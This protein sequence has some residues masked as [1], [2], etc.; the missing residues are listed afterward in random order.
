MN[1]MSFDLNLLLVFDA[2]MTE[3]SVTAA[4]AKVGLSQPAMSNALA[5]LRD[6]LGDRL[7][8]RGQKRMVPTPRAL[9][10]APDIEA[11]LHHLRIAVQGREFTPTSSTVRFRLAT[12]DEIELFLLPTVIKKL[13]V[14]APGISVSCARLQGLFR[15]PETDL[16][17]G[18]LDFAFGSFPNPAPVESSLFAHTLYE[19]KFVCIVRAGHPVTKKGLSFAEFCKLKHVVTFYP[20]AGPGLLDRILAEKGY[21][22]NI[23]LSLPHWLSVPF[24]VAETDLIASLPDSVARAMSPSLRLRRMKLPVTI[25]PL[26][27]SLVWHT[28]THEDAAHRW[29][30]ELVIDV[31]RKL[32]R[33]R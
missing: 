24:A 4:A 18:A 1:V 32:A 15:V 8:V 17:S 25:P 14:L 2:L 11:A 5:R 10:L 16:Q 21:K 33:K 19:A 7:F 31:G 13:S 30:R 27:M 6:R 20:G 29:F 9:E 23:V 12:T 3:R 26:Q 28:R 22:R